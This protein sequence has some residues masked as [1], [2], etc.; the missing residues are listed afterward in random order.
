MLHLLTVRRDADVGESLILPGCGMHQAPGVNASRWPEPLVFL[1]TSTDSPRRRRARC[2]VS[3]MDRALIS[4]FCAL[5]VAVI[6]GPTV[7]AACSRAKQ[8]DVLEEGASYEHEHGDGQ[9]LRSAL[10]HP[11][12]ENL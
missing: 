8:V 2:T 12:S 11:G 7:L 3:H 10:R 4:V 1:R 9:A 6:F 5:F